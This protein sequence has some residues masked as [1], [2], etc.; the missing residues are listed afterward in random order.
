MIVAVHPQSPEKAKKET[1]D[2]ITEESPPEKNGDG[3]EP[4]TDTP[5]EDSIPYVGGD[6]GFGP[7][8]QDRKRF[9]W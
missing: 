3:T 9:G 7:G 4:Q 6:A 5:K 8:V 1:G 2:M